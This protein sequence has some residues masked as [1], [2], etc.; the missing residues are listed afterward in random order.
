MLINR[1]SN[2]AIDVPWCD[3][4]DG[5]QLQQVTQYFNS[6]QAFRFESV[7]TNLTGAPTIMQ[8]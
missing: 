1:H 7:T 5:V 3:A 4:G 6:C 2:K 8:P